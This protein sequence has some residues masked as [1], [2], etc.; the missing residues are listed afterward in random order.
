ML[1]SIAV[2]LVPSPRSQGLEHEHTQLEQWHATM[3]KEIDAQFRD[4]LDNIEAGSEVGQLYACVC[5]CMSARGV[6]ECERCV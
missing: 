4:D 3:L 1:I 5:R 6:Y 2:Q